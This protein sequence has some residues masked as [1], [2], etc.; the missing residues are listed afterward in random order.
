MFLAV[1]RL[2]SESSFLAIITVPSYDAF[3]PSK[4]VVHG[5]SIPHLI[6]KNHNTLY[7]FIQC[8]IKRLLALIQKT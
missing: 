4:I 5:I 7:H 6:P 1:K 2:D 8:L 3:L